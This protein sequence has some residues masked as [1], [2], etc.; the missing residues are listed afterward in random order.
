MNE[1]MNVV[2]VEFNILQMQRMEVP[3]LLH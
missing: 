1:W 3:T 2:G